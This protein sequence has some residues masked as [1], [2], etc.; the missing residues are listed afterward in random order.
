MFQAGQLAA[1]GA[2]VARHLLGG[3]VVQVGAEGGDL[4]HL[5][6]APAPE[7]HVHDAKAPADDESAPE[8]SLDL[9]RRGIGGYV[10]I[11]G[12]Q[13]D[14]QVAH[15]ATHHIGFETGLLQRAHHVER[16]LVDQR[17]VDAVLCHRHFNT[18]AKTRFGAAR[19]AFAEQLV[20]EILDHEWVGNRSSM[21]QP[22]A[23]AS[24]R[25]RVSGLVAIGSSQCSSK[26]RSFIES[27]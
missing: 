9:L 13:P 17:R 19:S 18:F 5:V 8:Q 20:Y 6:L 1:A 21:R 11:L 27:E 24:T 23:L 3:G 15:R 14:Q 7:H 2:F 22:R 26:G 4:D 10:E 16:A 12:A 25:R